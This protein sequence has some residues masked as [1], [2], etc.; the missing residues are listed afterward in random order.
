MPAGRT[1]LLAREDGQPL[2]L[3]AL[4]GHLLDVPRIVPEILVTPAQRVELLI[5][6]AE[7][8]EVALVHRPYSRGAR[9]EPSRA[10]RLLTVAASTSLAATPIPERL[11]A[12]E[13][14][15][16]AAVARR[17]SFRMAMA[18]MHADGKCRAGA[19]CRSCSAGRPG[20]LGDHQRRHAGPC[21]PPAHMAVP[22]LAA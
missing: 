11:A 3:I 4:D 12:L 21:V 10:E 13:R 8:Q 9:R 16:P 19:R 20:V 17:R 14:L 18:F 1:L 5:L 6:V 22:G 15:D 7:G 2:T